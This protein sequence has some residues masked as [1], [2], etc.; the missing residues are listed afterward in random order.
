MNGTQQ[1]LTAV[2]AA[3]IKAGLSA[4]DQGDTCVVPLGPMPTAS[5]WLATPMSDRAVRSQV[6]NVSLTPESFPLF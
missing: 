6:A 2:T 4:V 5:G 3:I 1:T